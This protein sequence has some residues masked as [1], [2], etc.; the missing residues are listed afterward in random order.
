MRELQ[1]TSGFRFACGKKKTKKPTEKKK[2][3]KRLKP[4]GEKKTLT[5]KKRKKTRGEYFRTDSVG[6][7]III[8]VVINAPVRMDHSV[9]LPLLCSVVGVYTLRS[10]N[11]RDSP[12]GRRTRG[13]RRQRSFN[14]HPHMGSTR[15]PPL[16]RCC[17]AV[18]V[19]LQLYSAAAGLPRATAAAT[20][21]RQNSA[22][23]G[24]AVVNGERNDGYYCY[25]YKLS[26][27]R[28]RR[29]GVLIPRRRDVSFHLARGQNA[30]VASNA[31]S[32]NGPAA[33]GSGGRFPTSAVAPGPRDIFGK[34]P[35]E[36]R[37][38]SVRFPPEF[39]TPVLFTNLSPVTFVNTV[40]P[41]IYRCGYTIFA[42]MKYST[43]F[44]LSSTRWF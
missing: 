30:L 25:Y 41:G 9:S 22:D 8:I 20:E 7:I 4:Y 33:I 31:V 18:A 40:G 44:V 13:F 6:R 5:R 39:C 38:S 15:P 23:D 17:Y 43:Y 24:H 21:Q 14:P 28:A 11:R 3:R 36:N 37:F 12:D 2:K 29:R 19:V 1:I 16:Y 42:L 27:P 10:E 32:G 26:P 35:D 34:K